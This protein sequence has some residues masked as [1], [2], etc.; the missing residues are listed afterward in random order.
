M[1]CLEMLL[2]MFWSWLRSLDWHF[3]HQKV[4]K[5]ML[6]LSSDV[7]FVHILLLQDGLERR[8]YKESGFLKEVAEVVRTGNAFIHSH[9]F[10]WNFVWF[11]Y[12][13][14][15]PLKMISLTSKHLRRSFHPSV[16]LSGQ[17][18]R[19]NPHLKKRSHHVNAL[20]QK[21]SWLDRLIN[22]MGF[23]H[24]VNWNQAIC[25]FD[26]AWALTHIHNWII[27]SA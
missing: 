16:L 25:T 23:S 3:M 9:S 10:S 1:G 19:S 17:N 7:Y 13:Y 4:G 5:C 26:F 14:S 6:S 15:T 8:G 27:R 22:C 11:T 12:L 20:Y 21:L 24:A 2:K 18:A